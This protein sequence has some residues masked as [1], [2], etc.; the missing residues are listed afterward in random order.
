MLPAARNAV[1][2]VAAATRASASATA[3]A[4][5]L[6]YGQKGQR[7]QRELQPAP[8]ASFRLVVGAL[9]MSA[10]ETVCG[11]CSTETAAVRAWL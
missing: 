8:D 7:R 11:G 1:C 6:Q 2:S 10:G 9:G 3:A 4:V 5:R